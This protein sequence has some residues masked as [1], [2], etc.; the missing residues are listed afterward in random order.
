[1]G[2]LKREPLRICPSC[3]AASSGIGSPV[4]EG[5]IRYEG[6]Y[7]NAYIHPIPRKGNPEK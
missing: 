3:G 5:T 7:G 1:M 6:M 4:L 2:S